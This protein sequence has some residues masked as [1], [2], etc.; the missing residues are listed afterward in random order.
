MKEI[1]MV[2][3]CCLFRATIA[4][5]AVFILAASITVNPAQARADSRVLK[6]DAF[7][8]SLINDIRITVEATTETNDE[9]KA[10]INAVVD[11]Y[12]DV[13]G[14]TRF[15]AGRYWRAASDEQRVHYARQF[16]NVLVNTASRQFDQIKGLT[17]IP[18]ISKVRGD[19]LILVGGII[20]DGTGALPDV[21]IFWR[22]SAIAGQPM[23]VIDVQIENISMLKTQR[24]EN[25]AIIRRGGGSFDALLQSLDE[26]LAAMAKQ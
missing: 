16:R 20:K 22:V 3:L 10:A 24:D 18:T 8:L 6:A 15:S 23:R 2:Q 7:I 13:D 12:F 14:I 9:R 5:F 21:E 4:F 11:T 26:R 19:K 1:I 17:F 25:E